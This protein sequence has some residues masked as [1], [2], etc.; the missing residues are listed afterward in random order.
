MPTTLRKHVSVA[1]AEDHPLMR[2]ALTALINNTSDYRIDII[3]KDG[4]D[5]LK[6]LEINLLP[7]IILLDIYMP[8]INGFEAMPIIQKKYKKIKVVVISAFNDHVSIIRMIKLGA[9]GYLS[10]NAEPE[11]IV[12]TLHNVYHHGEYLPDLSKHDMLS[13]EKEM[14]ERILTITQKEFT[15]LKYACTGLAYKEIAEKMHVGRFTV[16]DYRNSLY[17][18]FD[19]NSRM[20]LVLFALKY[21][22]VDVEL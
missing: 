8:V 20:G 15:F 3:A 4:E 19:I 2:N 22:L 11:D 6:Q 18:K 7:D 10:K 5:L 16:D 17:K 13:N 14:H 1:I 21:K 12:L 9:K